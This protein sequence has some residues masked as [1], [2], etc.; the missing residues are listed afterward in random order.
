MEIGDLL[1]LQR[2]LHAGSIVQ[3]PTD[4][5][6]IVVAVIL[7]RQGRQIGVEVDGAL[8]Q[9]GELENGIDQFLVLGIIQAAQAA[10][11]VDSQHIHHGDLSGIPL[12]G[13]HGDLRA[14]PGIDH[15][16][17]QL[18]NG[19]AHHVHDG[20]HAGP[21][22]LALLHGGD[23]IR[24]LAGLRDDHQQGV[25]IHQGVAVAQLGSQVGLHR[26]TAQLLDDV[27]AHT[28]GIERRAAGGDHNFVDLLQVLIREGEVI[29]DDLPV[30]DTGLDGRLDGMGL[31]HD[32]FEHEVL[33][34]ALF[35]GG[36]VPSD[37]GHGLFQDLACGV[38]DGNIFG[39]DVGDLTVLHVNDI[40]GVCHE[41]SHVRGKVVFP[42]AHTHDQRGGLAGS[43]NAATLFRAENAQGIRTFQAR[44]RLENGLFQVALIV[45]VHE[46]DN[47][48]RVRFTLE[49]EALALQ[50]FPELRIVF[51]DAIVDHGKLIVIAHVRVRIDVRGF[52]VGGP[53]GVPDAGVAGQGCAA[54]DLGI[55][56][57]DHAAGLD[58]VDALLPQHR[59]AGGVISSIF[60]FF[61]PIQQN[62]G[63]V[64]AAGKT[65]DSTHRCI[66]LIFPQTLPAGGS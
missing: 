43:D 63:C 9:A 51:N 54:L 20:Q 30:F 46:M 60:Q 45:H 47:D 62:G 36:D 3:I 61:Q 27:F 16:V 24:R 39:G 34:A 44:D 23:G 57:F 66:L 37:P 48:F 7:L 38:I 53:A 55:Q 49:L 32:L 26:N 28:A 25:L 1:E 12:G 19:A 5:E 11:Q 40:L 56:V 59:D 8:D 6:H 31:L 13:G 10:G 18:G 4:E 58:H 21:T 15:V 14:S 33:V 35:G 22:G 64:L 42:D 52:P 29:Q 65:D 50:L 17:G 2:P 41:C